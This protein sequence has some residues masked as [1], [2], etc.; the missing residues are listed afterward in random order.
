[1]EGS[2]RYPAQDASRGHSAQNPTQ[3]PQRGWREIAR[4]VKDSL[5]DDN[6]SLLAG[7]TA[8]FLLLGLV[9][10]LAALI[11]IYGLIANP[12]D[13]EAQFATIS[14][15]VPAE[16]R[17]ILEAQM[18]RIAGQRQAAGIAAVVSIVLALW[19]AGAAMKAVMNAL[20]IIYDEEERRSYVKLTLTALALTAGLVVLGAISVGLIVALPPILAHL[21]LGNAAQTAVSILRWPFL[22]VVALLALAAVYRYAPCRAT[23]KWQWVS[24]GA[25]V[26]TVLWVLASFLFGLYAQHFGSYNKT[27]G[28]LGA[29]VVMMM[30][31]YLSAFSLLLGAEINAESEHQAGADTTTGPPRAMGQRGAYVAD[32]PA[33]PH[34]D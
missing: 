12:S 32:T 15:A 33:K 26:A 13:I 34:A 11:S 2:R 21:G 18:T 22:L 6:V 19:G 28:S 4:R 29:I 30:W 17:S 31:L 24:P 3:I 20:N 14:G 16:V 25:V 9:P 5:A 27:Y 23:P 8:F 7:G 1:M 10:G